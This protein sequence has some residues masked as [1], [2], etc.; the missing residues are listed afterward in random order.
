MIEIENLF[1]QR[2]EFQLSIRK[3]SLRS[4]ITLLVGRNGAG[5]S[6]LLQLL[7]TALL[8]AAGEIRYGGKRT[9]DDLPMIRSQIGFL[10][11]GI[12]L[13]E[14]MTP[15]KFLQYLVE[16]KGVQE[17]AEVDR[18]LGEFGLLAL[19]NKKIAKL[20][21]GMRQRLAV[22]QALIGS[23]AYLFLDEPLNYLDTMERRHVVSLLNR[24]ARNRCAVVS[25]HDFQEWEDQADS[26]LWLD[27]GEVRFHDS[28]A[29]WVESISHGEEVSLE[30][31]FLRRIKGE[32]QQAESIFSRK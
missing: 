20:P 10:P 16:L 32:D 28:L 7:A 21:Y 30:E 12:E 8:P 13:Y 17:R 1:F 22:A 14:E 27:R 29:K 23:P 5:K 15:R 25:T 4:G 3:L 18:L 26:I 11:A 24:Y 2:K 31:A 6:T 19:Q 9:S